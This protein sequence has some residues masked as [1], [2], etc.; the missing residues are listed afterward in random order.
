MHNKLSEN[1]HPEDF[2]P[3]ETNPHIEGE[4]EGDDA[5]E[6]DGGKPN[7]HANQSTLNPKSDEIP[8]STPL[9]PSIHPDASSD[10]NQPIKSSLPSGSFY[11]SLYL[12]RAHAAF[13]SEQ[14]SSCLE[15]CRFIRT[16]S[17]DSFI[18]RDL[19][20]RCLLEL[21]RIRDAF[22]ELKRGVFSLEQLALLGLVFTRMGKLDLFHSRGNLI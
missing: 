21:D 1:Q 8:P 22:A 6:D 14:Y 12:P 15:T 13:Q 3:E 7:S 18:A 2:H 4:K 5:M 17:P 19:S 10:P 16:M 20:I 9:P 11:E